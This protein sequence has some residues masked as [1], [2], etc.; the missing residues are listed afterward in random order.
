VL[1]R[2]NVTTEPLRGPVIVEEYDATTIVPPT[3]AVWRDTSDN[4][5]IEVNQ[6]W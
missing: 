5:V 1:G 3:C 6:A 2:A 4:L